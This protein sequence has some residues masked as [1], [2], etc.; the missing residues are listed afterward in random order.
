VL[1]ALVDQD[2]PD[3]GWWLVIALTWL[4]AALFYLLSQRLTVF[5]L[6]PPLAVAALAP[7]PLF[8]SGVF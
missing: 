8:F 5:V 6:F 2:L 4:L 3:P 7:V 1:V